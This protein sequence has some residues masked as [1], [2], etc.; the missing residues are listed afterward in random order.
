LPLPLSAILI[1]AIDLG[2]ELFV[3]LSFAWDKPESKEGLL[4][5]APR[6][7]VNERSIMSIKR[8]ALRRTR[9]LAR[10]AE[11]QSTRGPS[12]LSRFMT[13]VKA[14][15]TRVYWEDMFEQTDN[16]KL[17]DG[18]LLSYSYLEAGLIETL[19]GLLSYFVVFYKAGFTP[20][21]LK[22]AQAAGDY[23]KKDSPPFTNS[24]GDVISA[25]GQLEALAQ[26]QSIVYLAIF[27]MQCFNV[28]AVKAKT[29]YPF[30]RHAVGNP[31]NFYGI[32]GGAVFG[33][34]IIYTPPLHVVFGGT[35]KLSPL[36]WLISV[37]FGI[38]VLAWATFRVVLLRKGI[39]S[40]KVKDIKGLQMF[41]TMRTLSMRTR[42]MGQ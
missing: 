15:F 35:Y 2:F 8:R 1:L 3:G 31:Y 14:P 34:F 33:M 25:S 40:S 5:M 21:D 36:Y 39:E 26:A 37:A 9:T 4:R 28:F 13:K 23:F 20:A 38:V 6:K 12:W 32:L 42:S 18:K 29:R 30:G 7:P 19:G 17:V 24:R 22:T 16:E 27:I 11:S 41:P 10:D